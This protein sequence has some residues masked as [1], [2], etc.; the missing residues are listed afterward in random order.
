MISLE[1]AFILLVI[2]PMALFFYIIQKIFIS[3]SR[4]IKR[5]DSTSRSAVFNHFSETVNGIASI[6]AFGASNQYI[7]ESNQRVDA[8]HKCSYASFTGQSWLLLRLEFIGYCVVLISAIFAVNSRYTL[9]PGIA[10]LAITYS[11]QITNLL[12]S[13]VIT[14]NGI[15]TNSVSIERVIEYTETPTEVF[16]Y[17]VFTQ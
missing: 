10:G 6:R 12:S 13:L 15:E 3:S 4:Q 9:S 16:I 1:S 5:I 14:F 17:N 11:M 2:V 7:E 8:N